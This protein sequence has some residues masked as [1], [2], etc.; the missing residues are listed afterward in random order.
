MNDRYEKSLSEDALAVLED[1]ESGLEFQLY[2]FVKQVSFKVRLTNE[3]LR[4][5]YSFLQEWEGLFVNE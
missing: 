5:L 3:E 4:E 2:P 1:G